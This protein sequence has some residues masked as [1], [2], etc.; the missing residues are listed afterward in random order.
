[1]QAGFDEEHGLLWVPHAGEFT[2]SAL[3]DVLELHKR[4]GVVPARYYASIVESWLTLQ[5]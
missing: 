3:E 4:V 1:V 5:S 2:V